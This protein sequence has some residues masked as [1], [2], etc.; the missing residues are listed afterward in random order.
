A[1]AAH[2]LAEQYDVLVALNT[3]HCPP[4]QAST[5]LGPLIE[6]TAARRARGEGNL[7]QNHML[8][9]SSLP[10]DEN[11]E[12]S[13]EYL[14]LCAENEI[15]LEVEAG[16]VGGEEDGAS[17]S[18]DTP[19]E[20][21]YT[22]PEDMVAVYEALHDIGPFTFAATFGNVH[23]HYKPGAVKLKPEILREG[24]AAVTARYG[25]DAE[26]DLVFHGG[27]GSLLEEIRET[28]GYGVVKMNVDTDTQYAFTRPVVDHMMRNYEGVLKVDGEVGNKKLYDPRAYLKAAEQGMAARVQAACSDLLSAGR[29][30]FG[31]I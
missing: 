5:F 10:L 7:F 29:T 8:D 22:T 16:V 2:R 28:L 9:A 18:D 25:A 23:G 17:G 1:E 13:R 30:L 12:L 21:L 31:Q 24:Q 26:M 3:D 19:A 15:V 20:K 6:A 4:D 11:L 27:S 14:R